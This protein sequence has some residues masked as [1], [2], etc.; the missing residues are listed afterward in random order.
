MRKLTI[1]CGSA[2][3]TVLA[4][5][6]LTI[7]PA[8]S[9]SGRTL[10][11]YEHDTQQTQLDLGDKGE[12]AGDR[13]IYSGDLFDRKGGKNIGRVA[14]YCET[15]ST[16]PVHAESICTANFVLAGGRIAGEGLFNTADVFGGKTL[17]FPIT[18]GSGIY[19]NVR[20]S[21]TV[22]VPQNVPN[23]TDANFVLDLS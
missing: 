6:G 3:A 7:G 1:L 8:D 16:G 5:T 21:G 15:V 12:S 19:R 20:G 2:A 4:V 18:G 9:A 17:A 11:L 14:G 10:R 13:F 23:Y 22:N